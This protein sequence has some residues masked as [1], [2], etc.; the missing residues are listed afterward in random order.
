MHNEYPSV[1]RLAVHLEDEQSIC[2]D[3]DKN[4]ET[5][6]NLMEENKKTTLT[7]WFEF[8]SENSNYHHLTYEEFAKEFRWNN[9]TKKWT[10][11]Q[12]NV[13]KVARMYTISPKDCE[14]YALRCILKCKKG[15]TS[16]LDLK[17]VNGIQFQTFKDAAFEMKLFENDNSHIETMDE[18]VSVQMPKQCRSVFA[19]LLIFFKIRKPFD[20]WQKYKAKLCDDFQRKYNNADESY[21][22]NMA[23]IEIENILH[24]HNRK[25]DDYESMPKIIQVNRIETEFFISQEDKLEFANNFRKLTEEQRSI[26]ESIVHNLQT[27]EQR[28]IK[29]IDAPGG[30]GKTFL[31]NTLIVGCSLKKFKVIAVASSGVAST[32][33]I[34]GRTAHNMFK[35]PLEVNEDS[36]CDLKKNSDLS[37]FLKTVDLI[38]WDEA[39]LMGKFIYQCVDRALRDITNINKPFGGKQIVL[40]GDFRQIL[41]V[42]LHGGK[43]DII[44]NCIKRFH[45]WNV[46]HVLKL[47]K[48]LRIS[49]NDKFAEYLLKIGN[50][51]VTYI[52]DYDEIEL[53]KNLIFKSDKLDEFI[54]K[55]YH[56]S[57]MYE[58]NEKYFED[59][60][61]LSVLNESADELNERILDKLRSKKEKTYY[62]Y[63]KLNEDCN[64]T[65]ID[66]QL[67]N[68]L[69]QPSLPPHALKL[70]VGC[71]IMVIRNLDCKNG[72]CNGT[73]LIVTDLKENLIIAKIL[74]A[75]KF[76]GNIIAIP[77]I[78][79]ESDIRLPIKFN[80]KQ[81]PVKLTYACTINKSQGQTYNH[82]GVLLSKGVFTHG[83]LYVALSRCRNQQN[84]SIFFDEIKTTTANI[85][86]KE[87]LN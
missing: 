2:Y 26:Y 63:R 4:D 18:I 72:V 31:L 17:T 60:I 66:V 49:Q 39:P 20:F 25:L 41:P 48:N 9:Q 58:G 51:E 3:P 37:K 44:S 64:D 10:K 84:I 24:Q 28:D 68:S 67:L 83:Q 82:L 30:C 36:V 11:F 55:V 40:S 43:E 19:Y 85:V 80:V 69:N 78:T 6:R 87:I 73:R 46:V 71:L 50:G 62:S 59:R 76:K 61:I 5:V 34:N 32:L 8:N 16:F 12:R 56:Q 74:T 75:G 57:E 81:F 86:Y 29:F 54:D 70:K 15:A 13:K 52:N 79:F 45:L 14:R 7:E 27:N 33:I 77:R 38:I 53:E 21:L 23:L 1:I 65:G 47:N 42:V 35:I 22:E